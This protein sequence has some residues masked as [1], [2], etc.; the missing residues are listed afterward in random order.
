MTY[1]E[2]IN[3][4]LDGD[5]SIQYQAKRDLLVEKSK[6][7]ENLRE[8]IGKEGWGKAFLDKKGETDYGEM[9]FI[10]TNRFLLIIL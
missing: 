10:L 9:E 6:K 2:I 4:L 8:K 7:L 1:E 3:W 5:I